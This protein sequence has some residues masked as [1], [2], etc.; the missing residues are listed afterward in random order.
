MT[1]IFQALRSRLAELRILAGVV[2]V[3]MMSSAAPAQN[4]PPVYDLKAAFLYH[5]G[6]FVEWPTRSFESRDAPLV[7]G[8]Y[9]IDPFHGDLE[10]IVAGQQI[11]GHP[12]TV[13]QALKLSDL[14]SCNIVFINAAEQPHQAGILEALNGAAVLTVTEDMNQFPRSGLMINLLVEDDKIRFEI[15]EDAA[16]RAGLRISPK[17]LSLARP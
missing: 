6:Q 7:I 17:L 8:I 2:F 12:V 13:R 1:F 10:R 5:F 3:L 16:L 15:N 11:N 14:K 9:G 4:A